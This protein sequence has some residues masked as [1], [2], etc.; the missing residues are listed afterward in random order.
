M[1]LRNLLTALRAKTLINLHGSSPIALGYRIFAMVRSWHL[2]CVYPR[3]SYIILSPVGN[4]YG[5]C[6][7]IQKV[8]HDFSNYSWVSVLHVYGEAFQE[9]SQKYFNNFQQKYLQKP[10]RIFETKK[11]ILWT[12]I[13]ILPGT[14]RIIL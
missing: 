5:V 3:Y 2:I 12:V 4:I 9:Y 8:F 1:Y 14:P 13:L 6:F 11:N 7:S 10:A